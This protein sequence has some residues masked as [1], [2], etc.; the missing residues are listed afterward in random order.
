MIQTRNLSY[1]YRKQ[2]GIHQLNLMVPRG[3]CYGL[4]GQNGAGKTTTMKLLLGLLKPEK[5]EVFIADQQVDCHQ[6][7]IFD[8]LGALIEDPPLYP[9][10]TAYQNLQI[11]C[12]YR[13]ISTQ[14]ISEVLEMVGLSEV[15]HQKVGT[16]STGMKQR[17]GVALAL[18]PDPEILLLD[19]PVNGLDPEGIVAIRRLI[20]TLHAEG[21]TILLSSHLLH[22]VEQNCDHIGILKEGHLLY[23]GS[24]QALRQQQPLPVGVW[25]HTEQT[26]EAGELLKQHHFLIEQ[27]DG[28]LF[29]HLSHE[30][31]SNH[32][33]D[34]LR[35]ARIGIREL[36]QPRIKLED[37]Y[38]FFTQQDT[39]KS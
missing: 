30:T 18:L 2:Q 14:R 5:G 29:V 4:L 38:L 35:A 26:P 24:L 7:E 25:I 36:I 33:I 3:S 39:P 27:H 9:Y 34:L 8:R 23:S 22:E 20:Q 17:L 37:L 12:T 1:F 6:L 13:A 10:L 31:E 21:K 28:K 32:I 15:R 19:E 16:F 11:T